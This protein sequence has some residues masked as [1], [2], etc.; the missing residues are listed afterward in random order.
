MKDFTITENVKNL[1]MNPKFLELVFGAPLE[2]SDTSSDALPVTQQ[3]LKCYTLDEISKAKY[4]LGHLND[5]LGLISEIDVE[6]LRNRIKNCL[7]Y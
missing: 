7:K 5:D 3:L 1:L 4:V 6:E 2:D